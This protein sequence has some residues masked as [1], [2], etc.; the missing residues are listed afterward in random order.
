MKALR[1]YAGPRARLFIEHNGLQPSHVGVVPA[2]AGGPKGLILGPLDRLIFGHWL[3]DTSHP[4]DLVGASIGAWRIA[5]ACLADPGQ[6]LAQLERDYIAQ[7]HPLPPGQ[8]R[9]TADDISGRFAQNLREFYDSERI[10]HLLSHP[11][12]R[13]HIVAAR[14]RRLLSR[15]D[16]RWRTAAGYLAAF[17]ANAI[18]RRHLGRWMER[19]VFSSAED[20]GQPAKLPFDA[21]DFVTHHVKLDEGNFMSALQASCSIP[22]MLRAV[23]QIAGA[24]DGAYWDGGLTDYHLHLHYRT[25]PASPLVLYPHFQ[26]AVVPGWLDKMWKRRHAYSPALQDMVVLAPDPEWVSR[27]PNGKLP[28]RNDFTRYGQDVEARMKVW[29]AAVSEARRLADEFDQ[30]LSKPDLHQI[31]P[32]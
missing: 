22:F 1:I 18:G 17:A 16:R 19:V 12:Y 24:P 28:D 2:A 10:E 9:L 21:S 29:N 4:V 7:H 6:A 13:L 25:A 5:T 30:W 14:G 8:K 15:D 27:L 11:R 26:Q 3:S 20:Q 32:L 23:D 31:E